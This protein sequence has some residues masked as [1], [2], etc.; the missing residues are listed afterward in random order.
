MDPEIDVDALMSQVENGQETNVPA[1]EPQGSEPIAAATASVPVQDVFKFDYKGKPVETQD[2]DKVLKWAQQGYGY[3]Q[4]MAAF[5]NERQNFDEQ[6]QAFEPYKQID[7]YAKNNPDWWSHV[8]SQYKAKM[9]PKM[10]DL[11]PEIKSFIEPLVKDY[12]E[13]KNFINE[14][15]AGKLAEQAREADTKLEQNIRS[16]SKQFNVDFAVK[17]TSGQTLESAV[18]KFAEANGYPD[19]KSAFLVYYHDNLTQMAEARGR[20]AVM[21][22]R[23][24]QKDL[25]LLSTSSAPSFDEKLSGPVKNI[26][27]HR[28]YQ[29]GEDILRELKLA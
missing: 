11:P 28:G 19:F 4:D 24:R 13:V 22:E 20:E 23:K 10:D 14:W 1:Q 8:E 17:D 15:H 2:R 26:S 16:L 9:Q 7:E 25:G 27:G 21:A 6:R 3:A 18:G 29:S 12:G 5:K